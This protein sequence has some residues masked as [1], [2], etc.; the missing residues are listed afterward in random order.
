MCLKE[1]DGIMTERK[2]SA[3]REF[4][5]DT[6]RV[7][8]PLTQQA[9]GWQLNLGKYGDVGFTNDVKT[10]IDGCYQ[11]MSI[12]YQAVLAELDAMKVRLAREQC[13]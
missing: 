12:G 2:A 8:Y 10:K 13:R 3:A 11:Q 7:C 5:S 6:H 1:L 4:A 9:Q